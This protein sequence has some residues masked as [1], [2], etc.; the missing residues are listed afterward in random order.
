[1]EARSRQRYIPSVSTCNVRSCFARIFLFYERGSESLWAVG[2]GR[3]VAERAGWVSGHSS[4]GSCPALPCPAAMKVG[5]PVRT[6]TDR[7]LLERG[8]MVGL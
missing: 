5:V 1:M 6:A 3:G 8:V 7:R 4:L 2:D